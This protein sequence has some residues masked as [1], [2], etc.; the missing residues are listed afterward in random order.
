VECQCVQ[1]GE[2]WGFVYSKE[3][4]VLF[5]MEKEAGEVWTWTAIDAGSKLIV[6]WLL[7][8]KDAESANVFMH[9][10]ASRLK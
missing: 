2:I 8:D 9:D 1:A 5:G 7:G 3:K 6:S 10:I 4:N